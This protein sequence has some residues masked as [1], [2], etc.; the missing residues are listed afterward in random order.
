[1]GFDLENLDLI[2]GSVVFGYHPF[3]SEMLGWDYLWK[4]KEW[5]AE[6]SRGYLSRIKNDKQARL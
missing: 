1:M 6:F 2:C 3:S 4:G 5:K